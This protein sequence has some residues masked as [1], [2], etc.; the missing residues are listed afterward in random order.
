MSSTGWG[1][2]RDRPPALDIESNDSQVNHKFVFHDALSSSTLTFF[3]RPSLLLLQFQTR[4]VLRHLAR[5]VQ[6]P[7]ILTT[8]QSAMQSLPLQTRTQILP[9]LP[10]REIQL[11]STGV[12]LSVWE[13]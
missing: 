5:P 9:P 2:R 3:N 4:S 11:L 1:M 8:F 7:L 10:Q 12:V 6:L 13:N